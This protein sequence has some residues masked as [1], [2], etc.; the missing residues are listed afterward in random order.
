[1]VVRNIRPRTWVEY[2]SN[3]LRMIPGRTLP[4]LNRKLIPA[5]KITRKE[6]L[7]RLDLLRARFASCQ[8]IIMLSLF[9][10]ALVEDP[11]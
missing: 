2:A 6:V 10:S 8:N 1:M 9:F 5:D 7:A 3:I 4:R 11:A